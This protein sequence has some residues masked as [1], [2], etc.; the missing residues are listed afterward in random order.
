ME[1]NDMSGVTYPFIDE[2]RANWTVCCPRVSIFG[3]LNYV[4]N[5]NYI[6]Y[7]HLIPLVY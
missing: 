5:I 1:I 7:N 4:I 2:I 6:T 3:N